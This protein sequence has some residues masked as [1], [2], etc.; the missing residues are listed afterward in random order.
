M[1]LVSINTNQAD[2]QNSNGMVQNET[3]NASSKKKKKN[4]FLLG[5][6]AIKKKT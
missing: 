6:D 5:V 2:T 4:S 1:N 3:Q